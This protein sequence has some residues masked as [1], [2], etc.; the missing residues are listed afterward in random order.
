MGRQAAS[1]FYESPPLLEP[2][3]IF[4][5]FLQMPKALAAL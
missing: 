3:E 5:E 1:A 2:R 4:S